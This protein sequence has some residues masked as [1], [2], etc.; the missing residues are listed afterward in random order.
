MP[1]KRNPVAAVAARANARRAPGLVASLLASMDHEHER[2]AGAWHAEWAPLT[3]LLIATGSAAAWLRTSLEGLEVDPAR[4]RR[5]LD[6]TGGLLLAE[7]VSTALTAALGRDAAH[8]LIE[9]ATRA[10]TESGRAFADVLEEEPQVH[11]QLGAGGAARLLDPAG[12]LGSAAA[13]VD[14][15]LKAHRV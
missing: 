14:R 11:E 13:F 10:A 4:M 1:H 3:E 7:R 15:A 5:N 8:E 12:Y 2:A 9:R 6:G